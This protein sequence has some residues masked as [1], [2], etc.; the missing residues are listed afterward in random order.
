MPAHRP[1]RPSV[2][3]ALVTAV[4]LS[5]WFFR[6][7]VRDDLFARNFGVV[8]AGQ[9]YRSGRQTPAM[10]ERIVKAHG[11]KTIIDL[12]AFEPGSRE[13]A[14]A[15]QTAKALGVARHRF[16]LFGDGTGDPNEYVAALRL[17]A[18]PALRPV[19]VHCAAGAQRTSGCVVLYRHLV[20]GRPLTEAFPESF[21]FKHDP[22][23]NPK[24]RPYLDRWSAAIGTAFKDGTRIEY[25]ESAEPHSTRE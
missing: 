12:G 3:L 13:E 10:M 23:R 24:L 5:G 15:D 19:L 22:R 20:Q 25:Q 16:G 6:Y 17:L 14:S 1:P 21:E 8:E 4:A 7:H 11:I 18:D 9:I 2:V